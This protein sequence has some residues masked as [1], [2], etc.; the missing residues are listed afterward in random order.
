MAGEG[1]PTAA[2]ATGWFLGPGQADHLDPANDYTVR[3]EQLLRLLTRRLFG[4]GA[5][6]QP[7]QSPF[8]PV[9]DLVESEPTQANGG[10]SPD[11]LTYRLAVR[12]GV[13]WDAQ[14]PR[15]LTAHDIVRGLKRVAHPMRPE[16][17]R[18][19]TDTIVGMREY[20]EAY[21]AA[22]DGG[23]PSTGPDLAQFHM[24]HQ[25][26]GV[27]AVDR[28][29]L[30]IRLLQPA[31]DFL[32]LLAAAAAAAAPREYD[33]YLP[34]SYELMRNAPS[35]GPYRVAAPY[36]IARGLERGRDLVLEPN[37]RWDPGTD[38]VHPSP[39]QII[40]ITRDE[41]VGPVVRRPDSPAWRLTMS[42]QQATSGWGV[43]PYLAVN[44]R[45]RGGGPTAALGVRHAIS[46]AADRAAIQEV[47]AKAPGVT[48]VVQRGLFP[49]GSPGHG[50]GDAFP[51][52][53]ERGDPG[54]ARHLLAEAGYPRGVRLTMAVPDSELDRRIATSL[55][56]SLARAGIAIDQE[57]I[58]PGR[59]TRTL[60]ESVTRWD[61]ALASLIPDWFGNNGR[62]IAGSLLRG[63]AEPGEA[64]HGGY[65]NTAVE[66]LL[67]RAL[68]EPDPSL[69]TTL[70]RQLD[71]AV[72]QDLPVIPL[73]AHS[74]GP[75]TAT[76]GAVPDLAW[77]F[78]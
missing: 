17:R 59:L 11:G 45:E 72:T 38:R 64:N 75:C 49:P 56:A 39:A 28:E 57:I 12:R 41:P 30:V 13:W 73:V 3:P 66:R 77:M 67:A 5:A 60:R 63:G 65:H 50:A 20:C 18:Y 2:G 51:S 42:H 14:Y 54:R 10:L 68:A 46:Y 36:R 33:Y 19:F 74:C 6:P 40:R 9:P 76:A 1:E 44:L 15:E 21:R 58:P 71:D 61:L 26:A 62:S 4:Y 52:A 43:G 29:T 7:E 47:M 34:D 37:P 48:T 22:F 27:R 70:W 32:H 8:A 35:I 24:R 25:L 69:A 16:V 78:G 53:T 55:G 31:N 23:N